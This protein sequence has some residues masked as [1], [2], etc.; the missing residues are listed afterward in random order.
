MRSTI[1]GLG[2]FEWLRRMGVHE[3][4][5]RN[6]T[7]RL[8]HWLL[9]PLQ[10][11]AMTALLSMVPVRGPVDLAIIVGVGVAPV[12]LATEPLL[13]ALMMLLLFG[14][15]RLAHQ[16]IPAPSL[17][18]VLVLAATFV[19]GFA[20]QVRIGHGVF[21]RGRDDTELNLAEFG[22]TRNPVPLLLVFYYHLVEVAFAL[23]YRPALRRRVEQAMQAELARIA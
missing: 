2:R 21:E 23:G 19:V 22:R 9:I 11:F 15:N 4:Y 3:A 16:L 12:Y 20:V 10:L 7:N 14:M 5:H 1:D 18:I 8:L 6:A 17:A 13:G